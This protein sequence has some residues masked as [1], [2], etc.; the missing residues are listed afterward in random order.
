MLHEI[1]QAAWATFEEGEL[2]EVKKG[3][4]EAMFTALIHLN[5][6]ALDDL[7]EVTE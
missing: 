6:G 3:R 1:S 7:A 2:L 4:L 5:Q